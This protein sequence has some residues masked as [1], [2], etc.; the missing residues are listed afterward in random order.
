MTLGNSSSASREPP[1]QLVEVGAGAV[2]EPLVW[3][4]Q[5]EDPA[6]GSHS[7]SDAQHALSAD[8][9]ES[10]V[11]ALLRVVENAA[12]GLGGEQGYLG[13][14]WVWVQSVLQ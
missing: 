14:D 5:Q 6:G 4:A 12:H 7:M 1:E 13:W 3:Q 2:G 10:S 11:Q 8:R 9:E